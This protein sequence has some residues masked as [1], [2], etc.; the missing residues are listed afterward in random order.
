MSAN[1]TLRDAAIRHALHS[2]KYSKG[3]ADK[4]VRLLNSSDESLTEAIGKRLATI[5][6]R[7]YDL[8]P[9]TT[10]RLTSLLTETRAINDAVYKRVGRGLT[11]D[12]EE[13][14]EYEAEWAANGLKSATGLGSGITLP[15]APYLKALVGKSLIEGDFLDR[16]V[17][18]QRDARQ[19]AMEQAIRVGLVQGQTT[20]Q[21][22]RTIKGT[23]ASG[24][25]DGILDK[26]RRDLQTLVHTASSTI[27]GNARQE[28]YKAN[29]HVVGRVQWLSTLDTRTSSI[30]VQR[31]GQTWP[32]DSDHPKTPGHWRCRSVLIPVTKTW[33]ELGI[34]RDET[35]KAQRA[36]MDGQVAGATRFEDWIE[37]QSIP[38]QE[39]VFGAERARLYREG[40]VKFADLF[41][42]NGSYR[43][44]DELRAMESLG[45]NDAPAAPVAP[46]KFRRPT[47][48]ATADV[49]VEKK[50]A[51]QKRANERLQESAADPRYDT[52]PEFRGVSVDDF[53]RMK[54]TGSDA[55][56]SMI[57]AMMPELDAMADAFRIPRL[58]GF[59]ATT[60][61]AT[62]ASMGD[63]VMNINATF[64]DA[65][66]GEIG[67]G[68]EA[69][70]AA[71]AKAIADMEA[72][73]SALATNIRV[74]KE[75]F[76]TL[77]KDGSD[78]RVYAVIDEQKELIKRYN[79]LSKK[80]FKARSDRAK[81][82]QTPTSTWKPGDNPQVRPFGASDY[83]DGPVDRARSVLYH[84]FG[85]HVH[86]MKNKAGSRRT[87][88][89]PP[90]ERRLAVMV[91]SADMD[92]ALSKY[93]TT[94][95]KEWFAENFAAYMMGRPDLVDPAVTKLIEDLLDG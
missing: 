32:L 58:R 89:D 55:S 78:P 75:E 91:R 7:G 81:T 15:P 69:A 48:I 27:S 19:A 83:F 60:A 51:V 23:N 52:R 95:G 33:R 20:D 37:R 68:V 4:V 34:D 12:L 38:R 87:H 56:V 54:L 49:A 36:S 43:S 35:T 1:S 66:A 21:I 10:K 90:L 5:E 88:G 72:Q 77:P 79:A 63:G 44:L 73:L 74:L 40:Q 26:P 24:Y 14:S 6:E 82:A 70:A 62:V 45:E 46:P 17:E 93:S 3:L 47:P 65:W 25:T 85:H 9:A 94:N 29:S 18:R 13:L 30:C 86:Q 61:K 57:A 80:H 42:A 2:E 28:T 64:F 16:R 11:A 8:G 41:R 22:V 67:D 39:Q 53:G 50:A 84:E 31:D 92:R 59:K 76:A 71:T